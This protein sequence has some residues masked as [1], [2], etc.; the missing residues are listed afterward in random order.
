LEILN[1]GKTHTHP[2]VKLMHLSHIA[3]NLNLYI[4]ITIINLKLYCLNTH[5][6]GDC[7]CQQGYWGKYCEDPCPDGYYGH[8]CQNICKCRTGAKCDPV[9][10]I[11]WSTYVILLNNN[12]LDTNLKIC[13]IKLIE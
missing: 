7:S 2:K 4:Y 5:S 9:N 10:G 13:L 12:F 6:L 11:I 3:L 1:F 8:K